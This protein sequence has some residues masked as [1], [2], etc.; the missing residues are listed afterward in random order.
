MRAFSVVLFWAVSTFIHGQETSLVSQ[1]AVTAQVAESALESRTSKSI[2][3]QVM[4]M[5]TRKPVPFFT[6]DF[7][8]CGHPTY[9]SNS[10]GLFSME[11]AEGFSC[12]VRIAK[13]GYTNLD[14][15]LDYDEISGEDKTYNIFLSRSPNYFQGTVKDAASKTLYIEEAR[16]ELLSLESKQ[17]QQVESNRQGEFSLYLQPRTKYRLTIQKGAY[18]P[19][20][21]VF[22]TGDRVEPYFIRD[23]LLTPMMTKLKPEGY[24]TGLS[25]SKK[26]TL[27]RQGAEDESF[28]SIQVLAKQRG[29]IHVKSYEEVLGS[30]GV[31]FVD[32]EVSLDKLKVGKFNSRSIAERV[33]SK[34]KEETPFA[35]AFITKQVPL[36]L[37]ANGV[38]FVG[39]RYMVRLAS[40]LN[41][42][43][44]NPSQVAELGHIK[45]L[46]KD[47]WTI[48]LIEGFKTLDDAK[49]AAEKSRE[50]GFRS[51]HVVFWDNDRIKRVN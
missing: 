43:L 23:I 16:I 50:N 38:E 44:F 17:V 45:A 12:Y 6:I 39:P 25:V 32:R 37:A 24:V 13:S 47:E 20:E 22:E 35:H 29:T 9:E 51:A 31:L 2:S 14:L 33:L 4:D 30:Y 27:H 8:S 41:P 10:T 26:E 48:M 21:K 7:S 18:K 34:I 5:G 3:I 28:Y 19:F 1:A 42:E 11:T 46:E 15:L 49:L 40:Y 36:K